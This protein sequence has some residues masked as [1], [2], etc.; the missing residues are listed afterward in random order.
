MG[1][2]GLF[3]AMMLVKFLT[4]EGRWYQRQGA[5][6]EKAQSPV[7]LRDLGILHRMPLDEKKN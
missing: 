6:T 2:E 5:E 7:R 4:D 1:F 3:D